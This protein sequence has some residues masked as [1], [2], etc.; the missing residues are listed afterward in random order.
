MRDEINEMEDGT[1]ILVLRDSEWDYYAKCFKGA[2]SVIIT[3][4]GGKSVAGQKRKID[5]S[6]NLG[7]KDAERTA[8]E[9]NRYSHA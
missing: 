2:D 8:V 5:R 3:Q 9:F 7:D 4:N 6:L 1:L